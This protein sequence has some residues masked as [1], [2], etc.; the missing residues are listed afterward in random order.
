VLP[1]DEKGEEVERDIVQ[2]W[3]ILNNDNGTLTKFLTNGFPNF[4]QAF[5]S[6]T[7]K[8]A[9]NWTGYYEDRYPDELKG[10][11]E[12][13]ATDVSGWPTYYED[14]NNGIYRVAEW[15]NSTATGEITG[16]LLDTPK[17][18][19][20]LDNN[21]IMD[22]QYYNADG[23]PFEVEVLTSA[24]AV[25]AGFMDESEYLVQVTIDADKFIEKA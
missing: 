9:H 8:G 1:L 24:S 11:G 10:I 4:N 21:W 3:E 13:G 15:L 6:I 14:L 2:C 5:Y 7:S 17:Y 22:K 16:K 25:A 23:T 19:Q 20:T 18:Y 12:K